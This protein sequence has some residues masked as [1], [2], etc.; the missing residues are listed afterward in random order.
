LNVRGVNGH[1]ERQCPRE[2]WIKYCLNKV[3]FVLY[4]S[5]KPLALGFTRRIINSIN[6]FC[7]VF[8]YL[9]IIFSQKNN[10]FIEFLFSLIKL[11]THHLFFFLWKRLP[12]VLTCECVLVNICLSTRHFKCVRKPTKYEDKIN[13][14]SH[15]LLD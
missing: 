10:E 2:T 12:T 1:Y 4:F 14:L 11:N 13:I 5:L 15:S 7:A 6:I 9:D 3:I 8:L